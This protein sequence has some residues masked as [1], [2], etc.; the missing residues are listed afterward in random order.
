MYI[1]DNNRLL[2]QCSTPETLKMSSPLESY[3]IELR[4]VIIDKADADEIA[5]VLSNDF[6]FYDEDTGGKESYKDCGTVRNVRIR[7][8]TSMIKEI[9]ILY[10]KGV[11]SNES[12]I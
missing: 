8:L 6:Y 4:F 12:T 2:W 1:C 10:K 11:V 7:H 5:N 9:T 3:A